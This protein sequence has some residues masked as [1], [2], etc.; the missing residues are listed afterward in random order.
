MGGKHSDLFSL[1]A[2]AAKVTWAGRNIDVV[3]HYLLS[4][5]TGETSLTDKIISNRMKKIEQRI[6][7]AQSGVFAPRPG[8]ACKKCPWNL[9]CPASV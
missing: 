4:G 9:V 1:Y 6:E 3:L 8:P 5:E 7:G 2:A